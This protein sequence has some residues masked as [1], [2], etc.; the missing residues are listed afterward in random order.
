MLLFEVDDFYRRQ[1]TAADA[2]IQNDAL[3]FTPVGAVAVFQGRG[4]GAQ[5]NRALG[6]F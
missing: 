1:G 3:N 2:P 4:R 6:E 5:D